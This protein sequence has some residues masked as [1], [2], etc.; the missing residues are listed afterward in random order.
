MSYDIELRDKET[1]KIVEVESHEEGGTY[2]LGGINEADLNVTYNYAKHF[3][4]RGL[5]EKR[6]GDMIPEMEKT[7][8]ELGITQDKDYWNP[9]KGNVGHAVNILLKWAK[10]NPDAIFEVS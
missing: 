4:F 7:V 3:N 9:T 8:A 1:G 5:H 2:A 6:A 10:Q